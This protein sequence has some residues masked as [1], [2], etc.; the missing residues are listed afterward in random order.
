MLKSICVFC[1]SSDAVNEEYKQAAF[2]TGALLARRGIQIIFGG[3]KTG[4]MGALADGALTAGGEVVGV[5]VPAMNTSAL[6]HAALTRLEVAPSMRERKARMRELADGFIALPGGFGT[7]DELFEVVTN[8]QIG[9]HDK[10]I[11]LL[12]VNNFYAPLLCAI[13]RA[14]ADG[15]IFAEHRRALSVESDSTRLLELMKNYRHPHEATQ[16]WMRES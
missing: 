16:R 13:D 14:V 10:P 6:A 1:G 2:E 7:W 15:F 5:I 12:D 11:G 8:G 4:L 3:G 9:E